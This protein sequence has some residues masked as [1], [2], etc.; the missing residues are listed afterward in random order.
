MFKLNRSLYHWSVNF[1][2][3]S[4]VSC[5]AGRGRRER[6]RKRESMKMYLWQRRITT[7]DEW[8]AR[9]TLGNDCSSWSVCS[10]TSSIGR[11]DTETQW[12]ERGKEKTRKSE[13]GSSLKDA[14]HL[15]KQQSTCR[16]E[17]SV[18]RSLGPRED[19]QLPREDDDEHWGPLHLALNP[20]TSNEHTKYTRRCSGQ[21]RQ[22][23]TTT[24]TAVRLPR[25]HLRVH[26]EAST[27]GH[28]QWTISHWK[29]TTIQT[30]RRSPFDGQHSLCHVKRTQYSL[31]TQRHWQC[32]I[33]YWL[34]KVHLESGERVS[35][36]KATSGWWMVDSGNSPLGTPCS[37][38]AMPL[39]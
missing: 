28:Q 5:H 32:S 34:I 10:F 25:R 3:L 16:R 22:C 7:T 18:S 37:L 9:M 15:N 19:A 30:T 27:I 13:W 1:Y 20:A 38:F 8:H 14:V 33:N 2:I 26:H 35:E 17:Q 12:R 23:A 21:A 6:K 24:T 29:H 11:N 36:R 31:F 4:C 39:H